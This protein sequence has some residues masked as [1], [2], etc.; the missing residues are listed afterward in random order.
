MFVCVEGGGGFM[1]CRRPQPR[2]VPNVYM[3]S[4]WSV[5]HS[6]CLATGWLCMQHAHGCGLAIAAW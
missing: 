4:G 5:F 6:M 3:Q 2:Q 1:S